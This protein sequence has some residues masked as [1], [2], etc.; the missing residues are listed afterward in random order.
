MNA[1]HSRVAF[2]PTRLFGQPG[3]PRWLG[4]LR[5]DI[6][7]LPLEERLECLRELAVKMLAAMATDDLVAVRREMTRT[8]RG[9]S[10]VI[11]MIDRQLYHRFPPIACSQ[12]TPSCSA[13]SPGTMRR[14]RATFHG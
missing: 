2:L 14:V 8:M 4:E 6:S 13:H 10:S 7:H 9:A 1:S 5:R 12:R 11:A 3:E